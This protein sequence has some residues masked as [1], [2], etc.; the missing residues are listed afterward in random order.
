MGRRMKGIS[1]LGVYLIPFL[2]S[3]CFHAVDKGKK[4]VGLGAKA[5]ESK[6]PSR[7]ELR[8]SLLCNSALAYKPHQNLL[9]SLKEAEGASK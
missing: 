4:E 3:L 6:V 9:S 8:I 7:V 5:T 1:R 2:W